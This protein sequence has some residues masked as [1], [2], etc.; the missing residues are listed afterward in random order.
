ML[1]QRIITAAILIPLVVLAV[2]KLPTEYFSLIFAVIML[3]GAWEWTNL[4]DMTSV[5]KRG[6][7]LLLLIVPMLVIHFWTQIL[8]LA[9]ITFDIPEVRDYSGV[10]EWLV[11]PPVL[12]WIVSMVL[13]RNAPSNVLKLQLKPRNKVF[14]GAFI[15]FSAWMFLSRLHALNDPKMTLYFLVLIWSA[16]I[17]AYFVGKKYG[18]SKLAPEISPGKTIAGMYGALGAAVVCAV[19]FG[20][21][22]D[23]YFVFILDFVLLSAVTVLIS[24]YGDLFFSAVKRIRGVKDTGAILPGHGGILDR[25]DSLIAAVPLFYAG[26]SLIYRTIT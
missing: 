15:L 24:I 18:I 2:L 8:E 19:G 3:L 7:F 17:A 25:L 9:S 4:I 5:L 11:I 16:D 22:F 21:I 14:L 10:L 1:L 20:L 13:I 6:L 12:F 23:F 26:I